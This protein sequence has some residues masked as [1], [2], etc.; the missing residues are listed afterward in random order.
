[1]HRCETS[2]ALNASVRCKQ[3]RLQ[4]L[5]ITVPTNNRIPQ[6]VRQGIP[7]RRTSHTESPSAIGAELVTQYD[8]EL[9]DGGSKMLP[10]CDTCDWLAQ[11]Q[12]IK[13]VNCR[14]YRENVSWCTE[15]SGNLIFGIEWDPIFS[16]QTFWQNYT[17]VTLIGDTDYRWGIK[18]SW[19]SANIWQ[20]LRNDAR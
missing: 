2:N 6:A 10:W 7:D 9:L 3:K 11:F 8:Q 15:K 13:I 12:E 14:E 17:W 5:S 1:V 16:Y 19:L 20:Y 4:R 18:N